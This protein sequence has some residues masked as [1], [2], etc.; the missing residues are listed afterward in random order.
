MH[1]TASRAAAEETIVEDSGEEVEIEVDEEEENAENEE[2]LLVQKSL[3]RASM[4]HR[5]AD[6][7]LSPSHRRILQ[8]RDWVEDRWA[9]GHQVEDMMDAAL[10]SLDRSATSPT[11]RERGREWFQLVECVVP[12][13]DKPRSSEVQLTTLPPQRPQQRQWVRDVVEAIGCQLDAEGSEADTPSLMQRSLTGMARKPGSSPTVA[14][15]LN[16]ELQH[17]QDDAAGVA[18]ADLLKVLRSRS[19]EIEEWCS[20]EAVLVAHSAGG[21]ELQAQIDQGD[22][23]CGLRPWTARW[24]SKLLGKA[25]PG[26]GGEL[27]SSSHEGPARSHANAEA[28][29][30]D[31]REREEVQQQQQDEELY[32]WH[33]Q[34]QAQAAQ[35]DDRAAVLSNLGWSTRTARTVQVQVSS[36]QNEGAQPMVLRLRPGEHVH[37]KVE[38]QEQMDTEYLYQ[39]VLQNSEDAKR[40]LQENEQTAREAEQERAMK[41]LKGQR[42]FNTADPEVRP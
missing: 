5:Y 14:S 40:R 25:R 34:Q 1:Q 28:Q 20:I 10:L 27:A 12:K 39:G 16:G 37:L 31:D 32:A 41:K 4:P 35:Q 42:T 7:N 26:A 18:A 19:G 36:S 38:V 2:S 23:V 33:V 9:T 30:Y 13:H 11:R 21:G 17:M 29:F 3:A 15:I 8:L 6:Q 22:V 24:C